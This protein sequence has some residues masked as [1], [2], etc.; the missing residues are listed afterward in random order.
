MERSPDAP[1]IFI[2]TYA[3][4]HSHPRPFSRNSQAGSSRTGRYANIAPRLS[5]PSVDEAP[6]AEDNS[7]EPMDE[8]EDE[9]EDEEMNQLMM[10]GSGG[11]AAAGYG[12][13]SSSGSFGMDEHG[14]HDDDD[15]SRDESTTPWVPSS[16]TATGGAAGEDG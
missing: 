7:A 4:D 8:D 3:G 13:G 9:D 15:Q 11:G 14:L 1:N 16:S 12:G 2:V 5:Y 10:M 6:P